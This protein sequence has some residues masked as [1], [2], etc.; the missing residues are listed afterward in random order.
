VSSLRRG[1]AD[2]LC[3]A[4]I[5]T[6]DPRRESA[7][8]PECH[9]ACAKEGGQHT[10]YGGRHTR[11]DQNQRTRTVS[12]HDSSQ[13]LRLRVF[14]P[15]TIAYFHLKMRFDSSNRSGAPPTFTWSFTCMGCSFTGKKY[16][17]NVKFVSCPQKNLTLSMKVFEIDVKM[18]DSSNAI[19]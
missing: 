18:F 13:H 11:Y 16:A 17:W 6:D 10:R 5:L 9:T 2:I 4:P 7:T 3:I 14:N 12:S 1:H 15:S 19:P 8:S